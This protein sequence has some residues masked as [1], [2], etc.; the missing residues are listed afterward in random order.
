MIRVVLDANQFVSALLKPSSHSAEILSLV[1]KGKI[2]LLVSD[3]IISEIKGVLLYPR[4]M[5]RHGR[6]RDYIEIFMEKLKK[7][8]AFTEG[9]VHCDAVRDD[10][11]D[12]KYLECALEGNADFIISGDHHLKDLQSFK[13]VTILDPATFLKQ[14]KK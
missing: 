8:A 3:A 4:I 5:K 13:G 1:K 2:K 14:I 10:P 11:S 9:E 12:N 7:I 6:N